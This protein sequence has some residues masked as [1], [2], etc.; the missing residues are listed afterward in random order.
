MEL[1]VEPVML[2]GSPAEPLPPIDFVAFDEHGQAACGA[3]R[4]R[5]RPTAEALDHPKVRELIIGE[6]A[7]AGNGADSH[8]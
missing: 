8:A 7:P 4:I 3:V 2:V 1:P 5:L 6:R